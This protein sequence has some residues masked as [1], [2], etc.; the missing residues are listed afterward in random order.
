MLPA[1]VLEASAKALVDYQGKGFGIAECS[2][3][4]KEFDGVLDEAIAKCK[5]LLSVPDTH[6]ILFLQGGATQLFNTIP[7][8]FLNGTAD[9]VVGGEWSKK[10][11]SSAQSAY[12]EKIRVI[13]SSENTNFDRP[14]TGWTADPGAAYLHVCSNETVHGHRLVEWPEH[15]NLVVD[16]SSEMMS[17]PHPIARTALVYA[18]AQKN[19]GIS[20]ITVV[21]VREDLLGR[22]RRETPSVIDYRAQAADKSLL[23]TPATFVW[24]VLALTLDWVAEQGGV[25]VMAERNSAKAK[26]LYTAIDASGFYRNPVDPPARSWMNVPFMLADPNLDKEFLADAARAGLASLKGHR[27][28]GG[29]RASIYNAMPEAGVAALTDFMADFERRRG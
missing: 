3:R 10:A 9:Y 15:A 27:S 22:A 4:G 14:P 20:G 25:R 2:H 16:A 19:L 13:G 12:G 26:R 17:R 24:Y 28:V 6:D 7:M 5:S 11:A 23:N 8:N 21:I 1:E 18:G 29:M